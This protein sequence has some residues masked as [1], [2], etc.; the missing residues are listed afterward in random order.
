MLALRTT[1]TTPLWSAR[2]AVDQRG[3]QEMKLLSPQLNFPLGF[4]A[5][6]Y[7]DGMEMTNGAGGNRQPEPILS[8]P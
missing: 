3:Q 6:A 1:I 5:N 2:W 8:A 4:G 7:L